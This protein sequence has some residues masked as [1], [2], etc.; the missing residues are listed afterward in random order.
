[1]GSGKNKY[2]GSL[3]ALF[4]DNEDLG[5]SKFTLDRWDFE[6][7]GDFGNETCI[8]HKGWLLSTGDIRGARK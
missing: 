6:S 4:L 1:L 7:K 5:V 2:Y 3:A 8:I